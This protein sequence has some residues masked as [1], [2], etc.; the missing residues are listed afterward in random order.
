MFTRRLTVVYFAIGVIF[1]ALEYMETTWLALVIKGLIIPVLMVLYY[2]LARFKMNSFHRF[3]LVA[4]FFSWVGDVTLQLQ[5]YSDNFFMIG[6]I[7]F[8][9]T[10][11]IYLVLFF[12]TK[13]DNVLFFNK[14]WLAIPVLLFGAG[15]FWVFYDGLGDMMIPVLVYTVVILTML[16]GAINR[17]EKVNQLSYSLVLIGA[18]LFILS[19]SILAVNKFAY[20]VPLYRLANMSTYITAQY[21][22]AMGCIK[23]YNI[24]LK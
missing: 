11:V 15:I 1:I 6:L 9:I 21:L 22:I 8:L 13:G 16:L 2:S 14:I 19:D 23:Q 18:V 17:K 12:S 24:E 7:G 3:I 5:A 4:L 20:Q 10:Q